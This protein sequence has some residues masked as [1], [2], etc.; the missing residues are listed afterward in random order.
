[1]PK[2]KYLDST[3]P[4]NG[5]QGKHTGLIG[6]KEKLSAKIMDYGRS[7][8]VKAD[9][10]VDLD[11]YKNH[12][13]TAQATYLLSRP[14]QEEVFLR[15]GY[16]KGKDKDYGLVRK[17]VGDRN[18]PVYQTA[19]SVNIDTNYLLPLY[20]NYVKDS[21]V[22]SKHEAIISPD[23][24]LEHAGTYPSQKYIDIRNGDLYRQDWDLNDYSARDYYGPIKDWFNRNILDKIGN[25]VVV[26]TG[27]QK[28]K[29]SDK[30]YHRN[31]MQSLHDNA[32]E[33]YYNKR[34]IK[35]LKKYG[36]EYGEFG[37]Q[38][39]EVTITSSYLPKRRLKFGGIVI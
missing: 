11:D 17:A 3:T 22:E 23:D 31:I 18:I 37:L 33:A 36:L 30:N 16:I 28:Q 1:M 4:S 7:K 15:H 20:W 5:R 2:R 9:Y 34:L 21:D 8:A 6:L 25:P 38:L 24:R 14:H 39:P 29:E 32:S 10:T 27:L 19:P 12:G 35:E 26:T 13:G